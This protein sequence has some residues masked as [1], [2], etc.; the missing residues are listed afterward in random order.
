MSDEITGY[1]L[2]PQQRRFLSRVRSTAPA[3][4][5]LAF[6]CSASVSEQTL[7]SVI[8]R[9]IGGLPILNMSFVSVGDDEWL[10]VPSSATVD[11]AK[12][13]GFSIRP[14]GEGWTVVVE[15]PPAL[16]D[17]SS[18][19][20]LLRRIEDILLGHEPLAERISYLQYAEWQNRL[21]EGEDAADGRAFWNHVFSSASLPA[22]LI[23]RDSELPSSFDYGLHEFTLAEPFAHALKLRFDHAEVSL[24]DGLAALWSMLIWKLNGE[25]ECLI[26]GE[27]GGRDFDELQASVGLFVRDVP[28][29]CAFK[30]EQSLKD[31]ICAAAREIEKSREYKEM[32]AF[33][34]RVPVSQ[35]W[36]PFP[37]RFHVKIDFALIEAVEICHYSEPLKLGLTCERTAGALHCGIS[38]NH[39]SFTRRDA[40]FVAAA[41]QNI[42]II[43][44]DRPEASLHEVS[45]LDDSY[46]R[47]LLD[48]SLT[49]KL[50]PPDRPKTTVELIEKQAELHAERSACITP[51]RSLSYAEL[52][53]RAEALA[54]SLLPASGPVGLRRMIALLCGHNE[55]VIVGM[56]GIRLSGAAFLPIDPAFPELKI[57]YI[58]EDSGVQCVVTE[59]RMAWKL[60]GFSETVHYLDRPIELCGGPVRHLPAP[61]PED[62][63]Y[64]I[65]TSGTTGNPK[66]T[67]I[68]ARALRNYVAWISDEFGFS[69]SDSTV[70]LSSYAF[71]L[72]YTAIWGALAN[73]AALHVVP[74]ESILNAEWLVDYLVDRKITFI[75][76]TPSL[77]SVVIQAANRDRL[78]ESHLRLVFL[79]GE[80]IRTADMKILRGLLPGLTFVNHY[81]PTETTVGTIARTVPP[82][83]F[84]AFCRQASLGRPIPNNQVF[85]LNASGDLS[86]PGQLGEICI[87]GAGLAEG[88][89]NRDDLTCQK[90]VPHPFA[91][92]ERVYRTG[93]MAWLRSDGEIV[94]AGRRDAQVK[95]KGHR[96]ELDGIANAL[97][98]HPAVSDAVVLAVG[99]SGVMEDLA[100]YYVSSEALEIMAIREFLSPQLPDYMVPSLYVRVAKIPLT[101]NGKTDRSALPDPYKAHASR[102]GIA[103]LPGNAAEA[104]I[105]TTWKEVFKRENIGVDDNY[106]NLGGDSIKAIQIVSRLAKQKYS[107]QLRDIFKSPTVRQLAASTM[108]PDSVAA[109]AAPASWSEEARRFI[110]EHLGHRTDVEE[111]YPLVPMQ[112][113]MFF[114]YLLQPEGTANVVVRSYRI[115]GQVQPHLFEETFQHLGRRFTALRTSFLLRTGYQ[116]FQVVWRDRRIPLTFSDLRSLSAESKDQAVA[117]AL[118]AAGRMP[119]D[120]ENDA[121]MRVQLLQLGDLEFFVVWCYHHILIDGWCFYL[122]AEDFFRIY[123]A[124][125]AG[126]VPT[127][128]EIAP[129]RRYVEW[130]DQFDLAGAREY[131]RE[132]L[133][134]YDALAGVPTQTQAAA[135]VASHTRCH[136]VQLDPELT[137]AIN[138]LAASLQV[139]VNTM[140]QAVWGILL[141]RYTDRRDVVFGATVSGRPEH[142][143]GIESMVGLFIN[144]VPVRVRWN[145]AEN[146]G[147]PL[148][149]LQEN[150]L[151]GQRFHYLP[152][153][154][155]Q[156]LTGLKSGLFDNIVA[157]ENYP[158]D[159]RS[160]ESS[161]RG[162]AQRIEVKESHG[163]NQILYPMGMVVMPGASI[164]V[165][166]IHNDAV[167]S[168]SFVARIGGHLRTLL[169][170]IITKPAAALES[171]EILPAGERE[172]LTLAFNATEAAFPP[173]KTLV[174]LFEEAVARFPNQVALAGSWGTT[175]YRTVNAHAN[176]IARR[177]LD[178]PGSSA[179]E[180]VGLM[181]SPGPEMIAGILGVLKSGH[182]YVPLDPDYPH[183]RLMH[184]AGECGLRLVVTAEIHLPIV[185]KL[186]DVEPL[187][188][189]DLDGAAANLHV[190]LAPEA[191]A[192][193]IFTSGSTGRPKG[194]VITHR[195]VVR[196]LRNDRMPFQFDERDTW[197]LAHS[198]TFDFS[199]W[200]IFGA[201]LNGGRLIVPP[202]D[203]LRDTREFVAL[204][205]TYRV[206]ILN[207][208]P[209]AFYR[210]IDEDLKRGQTAL[211]PYLRYVIFGGERLEPYRLRDW[212]ARYDPGCV[213]LV[214]MYGITET[215]VHVTYGPL[216]RSAIAKKSGGSP[217]GK[218][219][220]ETTVSIRDEKLRL[221]PIGVPG[222]IYVG[223]TGVSR[224]Y[225]NRP[226]LNRDRFIAD[227][228]NPE[229]QMYKSGDVGQWNE[230]GAIEFL[231]RNDDQVQVRGFRVEPSEIENAL[232][233]HDSVLAGV[234]VP[235][236]SPND[237]SVSLAAYFVLRP[238]A[239][240]SSGAELRQHLKACL[241]D[242]MVPAYFV[243]LPSLPLT[244]NNKIDRKSLPDPLTATFPPRESR[245]AP[246]T[247]LEKG[248][249][250]LWSEE[251]GQTYIDLDD[252]FFDLGGHSLTAVRLVS[253]IQ[254]QIDPDF[255]ILQL[256]KQPTIRQAAAYI[257]E[258]SRRTSLIEESLALLNGG[259]RGPL[260]FFPPAVGYA[261]GFM[262][263]ARI[264]NEYAAYGFNFIEADD[265]LPQY[266]EQLTRVQPAGLPVLVGMSAG[267]SLGFRVAQLLEAQG[268]AVA[269]LILFDSRRRYAPEPLTERKVEEVV[270]SYL[271]EPEAKEYLIS[272]RLRRQAAQKIKRSTEFIHS[273]FEE[274]RIAADIHLIK[275]DTTRH[276]PGREL[277]WQEA[278]LGKVH[279]YTGVGPHA[280]MLNGEFLPANAALL[281]TV[282][283][284][285]L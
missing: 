49:R 155:L 263:L 180:F 254:D 70:L 106:F 193:V 234:V 10:Q 258:S 67:L 132:Y 72:G 205:H 68:S 13:A 196:L 71:D 181:F 108:A 202:R 201:L 183:E 47:R 58:L 41:F 231:G 91:L 43:V 21:A 126:T 40:E 259:A 30:P 76:L 66:G 252:S 216:D 27:C 9:A 256:L 95:V 278:T 104:A 131:W 150:A 157:F 261:L 48:S 22:L 269:A 179:G 171:V 158:A 2:S 109:D 228:A 212:A 62:L 92:G 130:L 56:L 6:R 232:L 113:G 42:A 36:F 59:S 203:V 80:E 214:N 189:A 3:V 248:M 274:G 124:L 204:V 217:I 260:F 140:F 107:I 224:G 34:D 138:A 117:E 145:E 135:G 257:E 221:M 116:P 144:T 168:P 246:A 275:S 99:T 61:S 160:Y 213:R 102:P 31:G 129:Y 46:R 33:P 29:L 146:I 111:A 176:C 229:R 82:G 142:L 98:T 12:G 8:A 38:W 161:L 166:F 178:T 249:A 219:L 50:L 265:P 148:R 17:R 25:R 101:P 268:R 197:V 11:E 5:R 134:D 194:C 35:Q 227:P 94:F 211:Q 1:R 115:E 84:D 284:K 191:A 210:Y 96:I 206:T 173:S 190:P 18:L 175:D 281:N 159:V 86:A 28:V 69:P 239:A 75:K 250:N 45:L 245:A 264:L 167:Y 163:T 64:V 153:A 57:R 26:A 151:E 122:I 139:T 32:F 271:D 200:E 23:D 188:P 170:E 233:D 162:E 15:L 37:F 147:G 88:Y 52:F 93:D 73:G 87:A 262:G 267:G 118:A 24:Q 78:A 133:R 79:G 255:P 44:R 251:L 208:T 143:P 285:I 114:E 112:Q 226:D 215:T 222:E 247:D 16:A 283:G 77:F 152:L 121:L 141:G 184:M 280:K 39:S 89:L 63:E 223:G 236:H 156:K 195:N 198:Y 20:N 270:A 243:E 137:S 244:S 218:P 240:P 54:A 51:T 53:R 238:G 276:D 125:S 164:R 169:R 14:D 242:Y 123:L 136:T 177:I 174:D 241:P 172:Q 127:L 81:G 279:V 185:R 90:F 4:S 273:I 165:D 225:L 230:D 186:G 253:R 192:Y 128:P 7:E 209:S 103:G 187:L 100:T 207:Q 154:E 149:R 235:V 237:E 74:E 272:P 110:A 85:L 19:Q 60:R 182:A 120:L 105:L 55:N 199:V 266:I 97:R 282:L 65:Y 220:P 277:A 119:F 83:E